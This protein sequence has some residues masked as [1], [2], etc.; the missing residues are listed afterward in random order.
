M[1]KLIVSS[2]PHFHAKDTTQTLM[3]DVIIALTPAM[4]ASV[5]LFGFRAAVIILTT[6]AAC[7]L[8]EYVSCRVMKRP[9]TV[10]DLSCVVTGVLLAMNLPVSISPIIAAFGGVIAI[11]VVKQMFG[12]IGQ[13][14]VN[15]ALTARIILMN[16]FPAKMTAWTAPMNHSFTDA[17]TT[18]TPLGM[19]AEGSADAMPSYLDMFLGNTGGCLGETCA[20]ALLIGGIYLVARRVISPVIPVT[21]LATAAVLSLLLG[22]DPLFD[23]LSGGLMIGAIFMATDYT[24][25]PINFGARIVYA[26]GC[27]VLTI[28]IRQFGS[29]PEGVSY[30]IVL[31]NI[32]VPLI[33]RAVKP[34]AFGKVKAGKAGAAK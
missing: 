8:S 12:G 16:S 19:L 9:Q 25:S 32:L 26:I 13:N 17:T 15:P 23:L 33:E 28:L 20:L 7:I 4:I 27:G 34:R 1:N 30:S 18:A 29:L 6:V 14:F 11:V 22:R 24:T 10:G 21:Y 2:S 3:L 5:I 31:M